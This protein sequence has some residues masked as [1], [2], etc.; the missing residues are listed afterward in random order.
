MTRII[1]VCHRR[2]KQRRRVSVKSRAR[3]FVVRIYRRPYYHIILIRLLQS[4]NIKM[5]QFRFNV[6]IVGKKIDKDITRKQ[7]RYQPCS[8]SKRKLSVIN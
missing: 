7:M 2:A 1:A 4:I 5:K 8:N 6:L 3:G